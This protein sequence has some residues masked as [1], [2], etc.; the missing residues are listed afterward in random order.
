MPYK[1]KCRDCKEYV[2][3]EFLNEKRTEYK[4][5]HCNI[6]NSMTVQQAEKNFNIEEIPWNEYSLVRKKIIK[7]LEIENDNDKNIK[8]YP[9]L[10]FLSKVANFIAWLFIIGGLISLFI[11]VIE[12]LSKGNA[13][14]IPAIIGSI[15]FALIG[16][17]V[18]RATSEILILFVDMAQDTRKIRL[19]D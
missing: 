5:R 6:D 19:K 3:I 8:E 10:K 14:V 12:G 11:F 4:C 9:A 7:K 13:L 2:Y 18:W 15:I 1:F 17:V 16:F